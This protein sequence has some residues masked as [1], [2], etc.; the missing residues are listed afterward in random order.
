MY[1]LQSEVSLVSAPHLVSFVNE[2]LR[3]PPI[4]RTR[5][6]NFIYLFSIFCLKVVFEDNHLEEKL[7]YRWK[8]KQSLQSVFLGQRLT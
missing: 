8:M 6:L 1:L 4:T 3:V 2:A 7:I 5:K